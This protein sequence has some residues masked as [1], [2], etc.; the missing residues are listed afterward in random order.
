VLGA[1]LVGWSLAL[2]RMRE[3][4]GTA[5]DT[6]AAIRNLHLAW[7]GTIAG[8]GAVLHALGP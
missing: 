6:W 1:L 5:R 7:W 8:V 2:A 3:D 4:H